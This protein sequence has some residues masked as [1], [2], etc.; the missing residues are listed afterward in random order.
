MVKQWVTEQSWVR[1]PGQKKEK[2]KRGR[3]RTQK[4]GMLRGKE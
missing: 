3:K 2:P 1:A 4:D